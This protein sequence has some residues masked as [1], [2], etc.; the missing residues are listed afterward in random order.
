M[1]GRIEGRKSADG[2]AYEIKQ[3]DTL[4]RTIPI[5]EAMTDQKLAR[6]IAQNK[7]ETL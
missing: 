7:W 3:G 5:N 2:T 6:V 4:L 1:Q